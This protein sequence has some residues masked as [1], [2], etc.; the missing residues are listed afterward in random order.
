MPRTKKKQA[1]S[2]EGM[3]VTTVALGEEMHRQLMIAA[4]EENT[5]ATEIMREALEAWLSR[6]SRRK[7]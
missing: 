2:R 7:T 5:A 6:R 4:V 1:T 3:V